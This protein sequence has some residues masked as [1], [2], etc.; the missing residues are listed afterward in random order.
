MVELGDLKGGRT[1]KVERLRV[2]GIALVMAGVFLP[3]R[4]VAQR[5]ADSVHADVQR[6][7][8]RTMGVDQTTARHVFADLPEGGR[9]ELQSETGDTADVRTIRA[10]MRDIARQFTAGNFEAP[11]LTHGMVVPGTRVMAAKRGALRFEMRELPR[12]GEV[13]IVTRDAE[14]LAAVREFLA[15]Q[16]SDHRAG[17]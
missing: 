4:L 8:E 17:H 10:H 7:G 2:Y 6:R 13:L 12:G 5:S 14:A 3:S 15:F 9:I 11:F 1:L 16:R